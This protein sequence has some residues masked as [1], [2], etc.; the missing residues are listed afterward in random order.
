MSD[1]KAI[2]VPAPISR[3]H[4]SWL[5]RGVLLVAGGLLTF[6]AMRTYDRVEV[7]MDRVSRL[8]GVVEVIRENS[9]R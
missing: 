8:E 4:L 1:T 5:D 3:M 2:A 7:L 9:R 6:L